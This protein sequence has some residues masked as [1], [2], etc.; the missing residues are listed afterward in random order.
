MADYASHVSTRETPQSEPIPGKQMVENSEG[1]Y[2][3][4]VD[5]WTRLQRF[6]VLG[7]EGGSYYAGERELT[8]EN[9]EC[10]RRCV[11]RDAARAVADICVIS[12]SGRAPKN[13]PAIFALAYASSLVG[14]RLGEGWLTDALPRVCRTGTH[15]FE[16]VDAVQ[17]FRGWGRS[18]RRAVAHW[19]TSKTPGEL[20]YQ[21]VKY[22]QR[23]GWTHHDVLHKCHAKPLTRHI[24]YSL[25]YAKHGEH[26]EETTE[27]WLS[28]GRDPRDILSAADAAGSAA[29][30]KD[31]AR[32]I[33][34][35]G[36]VRECIKTEHLN[37]PEVWD[38]LLE[39]MPMTAMI[40][41]LGKMSSVGLLKP[42]S[43]ASRLV[44]DRLADVDRLKKAR[45]HPFHV[46]LALTTYQQGR[47][48]RGS[49][50]WEAVPQV[51]DALD[52]AFYLAFGAIEP[53][54]KRWLLGCD[55]SGS[56][57]SPIANT[58]ISCAMATGCLAMVT[59]RTEQNWHA[60]AFC[61]KF[62]P[63]PIT[64][65]M[66]LDDVCRMMHNRNFGRTDCSLPMLWALEN[67][68]PVDV[69]ATYT[70]S[71]TWHGSIH[72][73]Q[74]LIRYREQMGIPAKLIVIGMESSGFS[75]ADPN[76]AGMLDVV[77]MD[78]S[79]PGVMSSFAI[80]SP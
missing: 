23:N 19:Y 74:A 40:R 79:C 3:F 22:R 53:T 13:D 11:E 80:G 68:V 34:D 15:L 28:P 27:G 67:K 4:A 70:D 35:H 9:A 61:D 20:A 49:L 16:F 37:S 55:V 18:L 12:E 5:D 76:D 63:L 30:P 52:E 57:C 25:A 39:K 7:S 72:P 59:A 42:M 1:G 75:I 2:A 24:N 43:D 77:G 6:L 29:T 21:I 62:V 38:A 45:V 64:P 54:G 50:A 32:L 60:M 36:L 17:K 26:G 48:V 33:R 46:L 47:G 69:F 41:N 44:T 8:Q 78:A 51:I 10:V 58:H 31:S 65:R 14:Q 71:E 56:M 66:R 73:C